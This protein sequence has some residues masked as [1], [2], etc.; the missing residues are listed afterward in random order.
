MNEWG[1]ERRLT[2]FCDG[3]SVR[4]LFTVWSLWL[5]VMT[6]ANL[7]TP[8]YGVYAV[9]FGF[10][11]LILTA[12]FA[13]YALVLFPTLL[14][15]GRLSDRFGRRP[16]LLAGIVVACAGLVVFASAQG[17]AWLFTARALQG[18][19]V[20]LISGPATAALVELDPKRAEQRP[21][22]L[23]GLA[24]A[25][26]SGLGPA[27][28]GVLVEWAPAPRQLAFLVVLALTIGAGVAIA[29]L[30]EPG[31][32]G[33]EAWRVQWPRV[34]RE[35]R[36]SFARVSLTAGVLWATV[37]LLLSIVPKYVQKLLGTT[38]LAELGAVAAL[39][40]V[41]SCAAQAVSRRRG[42]T[43]PR[44]QAV[45]LAFLSA[46][47]VALVLTSTAHS[48][49]VLFT[50]SLLAGVGHGVGILG[51]Q[52]ELNAM[53]PDDRRGEVTSA[54]IGCIYLTVATAVIATGLL[55][56]WLSLQSAVAAVAVV[57]ASLAVTAAI[58]Q[59]R[60]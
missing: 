17:A 12:I 51:T 60:A 32:R 42:W 47:L 31:R 9:R 5:V 25:G 2:R 40:F 13:L 53:A 46:G 56:R 57:L 1:A 41:A 55:D 3:S 21:A 27:L 44:A 26:G 19:A 35:I 23:A 24:Q 18:L 58:W 38:S 28:A 49:A 54:Y 48:L 8:L 59:A 52:D 22:L 11:S 16:V 33:E 45:G 50:G 43:S 7:A 36:R 20:G 30:P 34:P 14:L 29:L 37:A 6:G 15:L 39:A 10:S 4:A